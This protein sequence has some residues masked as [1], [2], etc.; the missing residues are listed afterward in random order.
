[1]EGVAIGGFREWR[2]LA[3][4]SSLRGRLLVATPLL[5]DPNFERTVIL[6]LEHTSEGAVGVV[7][8]RPTTVDFVEPLPAWYGL[9]AYPPVVFVG[10]PVASGSAIGLGRSPDGTVATVDLSVDPADQGVDEVRVFSGYS[11]W[12]EGQLEDEIDAGAWWVVPSEQDDAMC[13]EP[14]GLWKAVLQRQRDGLALFANFPVDVR[15]N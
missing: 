7:L 1:M 2:R 11:G 12:S 5:G 6:V 3:S 13:A 14:E 9:A 10:G 8:N 4:D 15:R